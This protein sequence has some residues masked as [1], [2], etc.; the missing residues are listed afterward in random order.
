LQTEAL[1]DVRSEFHSFIKEQ[2]KYSIIFE[3]FKNNLYSYFQKKCK[4]QMD[5]IEKNSEIVNGIPQSRGNQDLFHTKNKE[6]FDCMSKSGSDAVNLLN[7]IAQESN[8]IDNQHVIDLNSCAKLDVVKDD[9]SAMKNCIKKS[10][11]EH[12]N[13]LQGFLFQYTNELD[14]MNKKITI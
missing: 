6:L 9:T 10:I 3:D 7:T 5:W 2:R 1:E 11:L 8:R 12:G 14:S 4:S 13:R